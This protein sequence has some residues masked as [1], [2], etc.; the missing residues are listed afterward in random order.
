MF[1]SILTMVMK[2]VVDLS[3]W[4]NSISTTYRGAGCLLVS[5]FLM[6]EATRTSENRRDHRFFLT[7][8]A[9]LGLLAYG[10]IVFINGDNSR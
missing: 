5:L 1:N 3:E 7:G 4:W 10:A 6:W 8:I 9:A 2:N